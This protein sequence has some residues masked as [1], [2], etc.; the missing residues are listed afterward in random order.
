MTAVAGGPVAPRERLRALLREKA[1]GRHEIHPVGI[2]Q[3]ALWFLHQ[4]EPASPA[5][6]TAFA[7]R[8]RSPLDQ[9]VLRR[10]IEKLVIRHEALRTTF[11]SEAGRP[12]Q[13]VWGYREVPLRTHSTGP[14]RGAVEQLVND[15]Y[16]EPFDLARGPL[17]RVDLF[18]SAVDDHVV[19]LTLHH[20]VCDAWSLWILT[21]E[22]V[23]CYQGE[24]TGRVPTLEPMEPY[25]E[26][27]RRQTAQLESA[28]GER[29]WRHWQTTLEGVLPPLALPLDHPRPPVRAER[30]GTI[31]FG[32]SHGLSRDL[33]ATAASL[34]ATL[35]VVLLGCFQL[36]LHRM[37]GQPE[38]VL[39]TL[40]GGRTDP[41]FAGTVGY[42][43]NPVVIRSC[44]PET[45]TIAD[46]LAD[47]RRQALAAIEHQ[48]FPFPLLVE[49]LR[50][51]RDPG[52]LP[53]FQVLFVLQKAP[54]Q[55]GPEQLTASDGAASTD[56]RL[57]PFPV[58][59]MEGQFDIT[60]EMTDA[61]PITGRLKYATPLFERDTAE[62][63]TRYMEALLRDVCDDSA[64]P[65][66]Q[67]LEL[68]PDDIRFLRD[69]NQTVTPVEHGRRI[70]E[71]IAR[72]AGQSPDADALVLDA[73]DGTP[74][75][76]CSYG[77]LETRAA[78]LAAR[79][80]ALGVGPDVLVGVLVPRSI[81]LL[82]AL[83]AVLKAGGAF[84][85]IDPEHPPGRIDEMLRDAA[86][87]VLVATP[88]LA[89]RLS[90]P[91]GCQ[92]VEPDECKA[93]D[94]MSG[95]GADPGPAGLAYVMYTSGSTGRPKAA[96]NTHGG[97]SNRLAWMQRAYRLGPTDAV[98]QKTPVSFDVSV[99]ELLWPLT[100]GARLVL[101]PPGRHRDPALL[102]AL[103][104]RQRVTTLHF[105]PSMLRVFLETPGLPEC[106]SVRRII[107]S[108][109]ALSPVLARQCLEWSDAELHNLYGPAEA[110]I[111]VTHWPCRRDALD[112]VVPI[113]RPISNTRIHVVGGTGR[114]CP[115]G[116]A[117]ELC[118]AGLGVGRGYHALPGLT[119][120]RFVPDPFGESGERMYRTGDRARWRWDGEL[121]YL[122]R[123][124][125]QVKIRGAR[126]EL[127]E[128][129]A[130][131]AEHPSV[132]QA[133]VEARLG[134]GGADR[135]VAY[136]V[137]DSPRPSVSALHRFLASWLPATMMP[138]TFL[139]LEQLPLSPSGKLDRRAL[140]DPTS[141]RPRLDTA[142]TGPRTENE[143]Q[144][145]EIWQAV[146]GVEAVGVHDNF[147]EL[148]GH[149]LALAEVQSGLAASTDRT[150]SL[151]DLFRLPTVAML[152]VYVAGAGERPE[153][154]PPRSGDRRTSRRA[155][156]AASRRARLSHRQGLRDGT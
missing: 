83:V 104:R 88:D 56:L 50:P 12:V 155:S 117:G 118:I 107:C 143:R 112:D 79:L 28:A 42:F 74:S 109:E 36:L 33:R 73:C 6:N 105:V 46:F 125:H 15:A 75:E 81:N 85:P 113:G 89:G 49:R 21:D 19:L 35:N 124:D 72:Q 41:A 16:A 39:G 110:A 128:I 51:V 30:G 61:D 138:A 24:L 134:A 26:F 92:L 4:T 116:V 133:V 144:I 122:G 130:R 17:A 43:V 14:D 102:A 20:A 65:L 10:A 146:L 97:L 13:H 71:L 53:I 123:F 153:Q 94:T 98:L 154:G 9:E 86:T 120:E 37:A 5:Y 68:I 135:L 58:R 141:E 139:F 119:A 95:V 1:A 84:V 129:E 100:A 2:G 54:R 52:R 25:H 93:V 136:V 106:P 91:P 149:S 147:F 127:G 150:P 57:E 59:Q 151:V 44:L 48:D 121:E 55:H 27:C 131:L 40:T 67:V 29:L 142:Y 103:I 114:R 137:T 63:L 82:V 115:V 8:S 69:R 77:Q 60:L 38:L 64:R 7:F 31:E 96:M 3:R 47:V 156:V 45:G 148:G 22:L 140:P 11:A 18:T 132:R 80:R 87:P 70:H 34:G 152:A 90:P 145:A 111:D 23:R 99:W 78:G 101:C 66:D 108:G 126:V 32:L 62:R 76:T